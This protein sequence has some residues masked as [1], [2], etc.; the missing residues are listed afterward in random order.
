M[1]T[2]IAVIA[3]INSHAAHW[4]ALGTILIGVGFAVDGS[5]ELGHHACLIVGGMLCGFSLRKGV[6]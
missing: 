5:T 1:K 2:A 6:A 4:I 3:V